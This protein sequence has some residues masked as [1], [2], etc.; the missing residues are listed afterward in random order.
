MNSSH[1]GSYSLSHTHN[2][3]FSFFSQQEFNN[4]RIAPKTDFGTVNFATEEARTAAIQNLNGFLL[5]C[6]CF[7]AAQFVTDS[8]L[9][10]FPKIQKGIASS[11]KLPSRTRTTSTI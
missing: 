9:N 3:S 1:F 4:V 6:V 8:G 7:F 10:P 5:K 11:L 2:L